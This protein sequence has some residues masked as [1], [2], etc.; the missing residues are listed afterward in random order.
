MFSDSEGASRIRKL[1]TMWLGIT[2]LP[3][4]RQLIRSEGGVPLTILHWLSRG[5]TGGKLCSYKKEQQCW[6]VWDTGPLFAVLNTM[7]WTCFCSNAMYMLGAQHMFVV[8]G[9]TEL[10]QNLYNRNKDKMSSSQLGL[11]WQIYISHHNMHA[12]VGFKGITDVF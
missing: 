3:G 12:C 1:Q 10:A 6:K 2:I 11:P 8:D 5:R 9:C 4:W 7:I